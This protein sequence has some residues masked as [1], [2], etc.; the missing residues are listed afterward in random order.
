VLKLKENGDCIFW[1]EGC[2]ISPNVPVSAARSLSG[3]ILRLPEEWSKLKDFCHASTAEAHPRG[4][5]RGLHGTGH[6]RLSRS[7]ASAPDDFPGAPNRT[8]RP[9]YAT[10]RKEPILRDPLLDGIK[11]AGTQAFSNSLSR[12]QE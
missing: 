3:R 7:S 8:V 11:D 2:T 4:D 10:F 6:E 5:P 12:T 9:G 1:D